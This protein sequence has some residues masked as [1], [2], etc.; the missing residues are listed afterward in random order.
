MWQ[1]IGQEQ[2][3][4]WLEHAL[5][6]GRLAH[7]YLFA[8]PS[9]MGKATLALELAQA[10]NCEGAG[11]GPCGQ[12]RPCQRIA[13]GK[14]ADVIT[15][16]RGEGRTEISID[17]VR[18]VQRRAS[19]KPVE[20]NWLVCIV[21]GAEEMSAEAANCVLK[22]LEE[23][24]PQALFI[25]LTSR[26][27]R[28]LPTVRSRCQRLAL[29]PVPRA[30][31]EQEMLKRGV[32]PGRAALIARLSR[33]RLG[34][35][36]ASAQESAEVWHRRVQAV[37]RL[38]S[39]PR[40]GYGDRLGYAAQW[41]SQF[42]RRRDQ[43]FEE[44]DLWQDWW[45]DLLLAR[46]GCSDFVCNW[47]YSEQLQQQAQGF[48]LGAI[49]GFLQDLRRTRRALEANASPRLALE[50]LMLHLPRPERVA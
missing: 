18:D 3:I 50:V 23:P 42:S 17:Q 10:V 33:G 12:C 31:V 35:A 28:L 40:A 47:D 29:K 21:D 24:A 22:T 37:E 25:L 36:I 7:A 9:H 45:R 39:L 11:P 30:R 19:L 27:A 32:E 14:H 43:A 1:T 15:L 38:G 16:R 4:R 13:A 41:A 20:G 5:A 2:A 34:W 48:G 46:G 44:M 8:G 26:E 6:T 49:V